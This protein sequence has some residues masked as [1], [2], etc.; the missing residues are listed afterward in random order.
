MDKGT[1]TDTY[2]EEFTTGYSERKEEI[3]QEAIDYLN[4]RMASVKLYN[5]KRKKIINNKLFVKKFMLPR[6]IV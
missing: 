2:Y 1:N 5:M 3:P 4:T 6:K